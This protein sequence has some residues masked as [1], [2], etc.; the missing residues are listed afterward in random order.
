M[1]RL[2]RPTQATNLGL[3]AV[4]VVIPFLFF[5]IGLDRKRWETGYEWFRGGVKS[6]VVRIFVRWGVYWIGIVVGYAVE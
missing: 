2:D 4:L 5:V 1:G 3:Y 6:D